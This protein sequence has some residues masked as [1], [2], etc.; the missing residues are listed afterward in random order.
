LMRCVGIR[1]GQL[2]MRLSN[3]RI[4]HASPFL[5]STARSAEFLLFLESRYGITTASCRQSH[6]LRGL[7]VWGSTCEVRFCFP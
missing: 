3:H 6:F 4:T 2:G 7:L 1:H 5:H